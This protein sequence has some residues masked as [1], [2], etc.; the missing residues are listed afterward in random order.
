MK[1]SQEICI[2]VYLIP[3]KQLVVSFK[4]KQSLI[5]D[6]LK[7]CSQSCADCCSI[8]FISEGN[9]KAENTIFS[10]CKEGAL[11]W[12]VCNSH[13]NPSKKDV[14][15]ILDLIER[16]PTYRELHMFVAQGHISIPPIGF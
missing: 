13:S 14:K 8:F 4:L 16:K 7:K 3:L 15:D 12:K 1:L 6:Q 11:T 5:C 10:N 9:L 2:M